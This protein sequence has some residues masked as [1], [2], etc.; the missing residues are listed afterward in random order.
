MVNGKIAEKIGGIKA[1]ME[2]PLSGKTLA[3]DLQTTIIKR[4][5]TKTGSKLKL[6]LQP[7]NKK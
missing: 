4:V 6:P 1:G 5:A 7:K 2:I 3:K